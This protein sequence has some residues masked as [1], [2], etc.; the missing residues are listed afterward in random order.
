MQNLPSKE[1]LFKNMLKLK[2][3]D[4]CNLEEI[5]KKLVSLGYI[6]CDLIEGRGSISVRGD[7]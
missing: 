5:K 2:V 4:I 3:G 6:R 7:Y 1:T